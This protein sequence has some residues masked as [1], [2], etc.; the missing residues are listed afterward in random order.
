[1]ISIQ[2]LTKKF[3]QREAVHDLTFDVP[4]GRVTGFLGPNGA[5]KTTTLRML[6]GL[7]QPTGGSATI[8]GVP[9]Q[10]LDQPRRV[11][12]AAIEAMAAHPGRTG[13]DHL[14]TLAGAAGAS[15]ERVTEVLA[16]VGLT[17]AEGERAG[18]Y[19]L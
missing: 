8:N 18:G 6:L 19:S 1:M 14:W 16:Q 9:Y 5:G 4:P 7:V 3:G 10:R 17:A 2:G 15:P 13:R 12:G 11:V